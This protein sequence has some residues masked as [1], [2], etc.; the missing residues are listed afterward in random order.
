MAIKVNLE[1]FRDIMKALPQSTEITPGQTKCFIV[2]GI[3][4]AAIAMTSFNIYRIT[5]LDSEISSL[6]GKT[7]L[8]VDVLPLHE[9]HLHHLEDKTYATNKLL[10]DVL[11]ANIWFSLKIRDAVENK[12]QSVMHHHK[13]IVKSAQHHCLAPGVLPHDILNEILN[14]TLTMAQKQN[15]VPFVNCSSD[16]FQIEVS[17]LYNPV[18][19]IFT[20]ILHTPM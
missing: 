6:K 15:L 18:T 12:Y 13:N 17:H 11:E 2:L 19:K 14:H 7:D 20:L 1:D 16:L 10:G 8:L 4:I 5:Q 9:A 3:S